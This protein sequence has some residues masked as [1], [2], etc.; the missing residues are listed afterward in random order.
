MGQEPTTQITGEPALSFTY[1]PKRSLYDQFS[2]AQGGKDG[3]GELEAAV[4]RATEE[5]CDENLNLNA[6]MGGLESEISGSEVSGQGSDGDDMMDGQMPSS[7][8][9]AS[10]LPPALQGPNTPFFPMISLQGSPA[11]KQRRKKNSKL[12]FGPGKSSSL[13]GDPSGSDDGNERGRRVQERGRGS[14]YGSADESIE[15]D[16]S[17]LTASEL[18]M[19]QARGELAPPN[20]D[21]RRRLHVRNMHRQQQQ[22]IGPEAVYYHNGPDGLSSIQRP[23]S[24]EELQR[25]SY[26]I[27][28]TLSAGYP[29]QQTFAQAQSRGT[30]LSYLTSELA[31]APVRVDPSTVKTKAFACPLFSCGRLF[32]RMEH[33][34][35]H[36]RTHTM[37]RPYQCP[38]CKKKFSRSDNLTQH[39]RTHGK[40][41]SDGLG[42][43]N[44]GTTEW[45]DGADADRESGGAASEDIDELENDDAV[46]TTA[47]GGIGM[48]LGMYGGASGMGMGMGMAAG[49]TGSGYGGV[50]GMP[51]VQMCEVEVQGDVLEVQGDEE[52][53]MTTAGSDVSFINGSSTQ[54]QQ[55]Q[56]QG[57]YYTTRPLVPSPPF[58]TTATDYTDAGA[59]WAVRTHPS[60]A[61]STISA[62]S[63]PPGSIP[64]IRSARSSLT[65]SP[66]NYIPTASTS[67]AGYNT[68]DYV[69]SISAPSHKQA[70]DHASLYPPGMLDNSGPGP[71][72]RHRSMTPSLMRN[73]ENIR[74][75]LT[76]SSG[77][78]A[79]M[80]SGTSPGSTGRGYHPYANA[81]VSSGYS[82]SQSRDNSAQSSPAMYPI[83]LAE[84]YTSN[85]NSNDSHSQPPQ[86]ASNG[87]MQ[88]QMRQMMNMNLDQQVDQAH[89]TMYG[90]GS[91]SSIS[92]AGVTQG[93]GDMYRTDS[94]V[95]YAS[96]LP[97]EYIGDVYGAPVP[98][99]FDKQGL[100]VLDSDGQYQ[101]VDEGYYP[102][103][104][105]VTL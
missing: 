99:Q 41:D 75:P 46:Y 96:D 63:P 60:P 89:P 16:Y 76:A 5:R 32:K 67:A 51:D 18:F 77:D 53:L 78:F 36:L 28:G 68:D 92:N 23:R 72:R 4:R 47:T 55:T 34:K 20:I 64:H 95:Q 30:P 3:E 9:G 86:S 42:G 93:Y 59:Q 48:N 98:V 29:A 104:Q 70:F 45:E 10:R 7:E 62:P 85:T 65:S 14:R 22:R 73:G 27:P 103:T 37:E 15:R 58:T 1:D 88:E 12:T 102:Q 105:H 13:R 74:R 100:Y 38:K 8:E 87:Q 56:G 49:M 17:H 50:D 35:R 19:K 52:G 97:V 24:H 43:G 40:I 6:T 21:D 83:P 44:G 2:K 82:S 94:P 71:I 26:P 33:L 66:A 61:F 11:Y 39:V 25:H 69:T 31:T 80:G 90:D 54:G 84:S 81:M 91:T 101:G 79:T 57:S